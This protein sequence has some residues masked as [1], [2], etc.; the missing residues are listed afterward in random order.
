MRR[1]PPRVTPTLATPLGIRLRW[2][3]GLD[4]GFPL[5]L[6]VFLMHFRFF[7][8]R[9]GFSWGLEPGNAPK[10]AHE[11]RSE[12]DQSTMTRLLV[13]TLLTVKYTTT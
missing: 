3:S 11:A 7:Y 1:L 13:D 10:Y 6:R 8:N 12:R 4:W 2:G 5:I 9:N